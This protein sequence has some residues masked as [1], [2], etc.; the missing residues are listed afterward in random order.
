MK[1]R[2]S[3]IETKSEARNDNSPGC[4]K[5]ATYDIIQLLPTTPKISRSADQEKVSSDFEAVSRSA[6]AEGISPAAI[7]VA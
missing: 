4:R 7:R 5:R 6:T 3:S 1:K 2:Y